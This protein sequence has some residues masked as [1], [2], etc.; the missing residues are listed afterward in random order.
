[1]NVI[2]QRPLQPLAEWTLE[3]WQSKQRVPLLVCPNEYKLRTWFFLR[4]AA[5]IRQR[6][7]DTTPI[8][9]YCLAGSRAAPM[10]VVSRQWTSW[11]LRKIPGDSKARIHRSLTVPRTVKTSRLQIVI[12]SEGLADTHEFET[13]WLGQALTGLPQAA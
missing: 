3:A 7:S 13:L 6:L 8:E 4:Y 12:S 10:D 11:Q 2:R 1:M 9:F 5:A